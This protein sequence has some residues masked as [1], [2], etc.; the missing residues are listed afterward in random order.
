[1]SKQRTRRPKKS[2]VEPDSGA[3]ISFREG[4]GGAVSGSFHGLEFERRPVA[5]PGI[6][7]FARPIGQGAITL[8]RRGEPVRAVEVAAEQSM[9]RVGG[10]HP[11]ADP[12]AAPYAGIAIEIV[13]MT[14]VHGP[15]V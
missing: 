1:M 3:A 11:D 15:A 2:Y 4:D 10:G 9:E 13:R 7:V 12:I 14:D 5:A 6:E 8:D